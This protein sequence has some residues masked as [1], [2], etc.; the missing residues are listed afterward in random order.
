MSTQFSCTTSREEGTYLYT[1][2]GPELAHC[3][4]SSDVRLTRAADAHL[5]VYAFK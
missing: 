5:Q 4:N 1:P 2:L 3:C